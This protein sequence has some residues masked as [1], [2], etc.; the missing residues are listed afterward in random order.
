MASPES[1]L[2]VDTS[3]SLPPIIK[4]QAAAADAAH[5]AAYSPE[6]DPPAADAVAQPDVPV[7]DQPVADPPAP[8]PNEPVREPAP[9]AQEPEPQ[10]STQ[11]EPGSWEHRYFSMEGRYRQSQ[12]TIGQL[13]EQMREMSDEMVRLQEHQQRTQP[14]RQNA[15]TPAPKLVTD[16]D[17]E[18]YGPEL[19][20]MVQRAARDAVA[21]EIDQVRNQT[22]QVSQRVMQNTKQTLNQTL[23]QQ[24]PE[25]RDLNRNPRFRD[26]CSSR[27]VYS[28]Q[29]R[30]QMLNAAYQAADAPRVVAFFKGFQAEELATGNAPAPTAQQQQAAPV[31]REAARSLETLTAPGRAKPATGNSVASSA[32]KPVFTRAQISEFY[33]NVNA[34][35]YSGRQAEKDKVEQA[36]FAAQNDGRVR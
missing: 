18:V 13:Q 3:V 23:D 19:L 30:G 32:D 21:P 8:A 6:P 10:R 34:G 9:A 33:R 25:W 17:T 7:Q 5:K 20:A 28:G 15:P 14:V 22:R 24:V 1:N 12:N 36:I 27:D 29:V 16:Q 4:R 11:V 26:W 31:P 35:R 2:P